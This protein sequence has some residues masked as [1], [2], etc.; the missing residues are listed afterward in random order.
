MIKDEL[1][2][3][4]PTNQEMHVILNKEQLKEIELFISKIL[5]FKFEV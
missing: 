4:K 3:T 5:G 2:L 1:L